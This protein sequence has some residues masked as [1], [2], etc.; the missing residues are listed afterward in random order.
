[1]S[2]A[3]TDDRRAFVDTGAYYALVNRHDERHEQ[4]R[5]ILAA[6]LPL[7]PRLYTTNFVVAETHALVLTR[8]GRDLAAR[9]LAD[10]DGSA[11]TTVVRVTAADERRARAIIAQYT[12]KDF[13]LTDTTSFAV[14][15]RLGL[16]RAF[17]FDRHF[18]QY[19]FRLLASPDPTSR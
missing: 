9:V 4:A 7:H 8:L 3:P 5:A 17:A 10:I 14:M 19:G 6:L 2:S 13:S 11:A 1:M 16:R 18:V 15:E 12:D